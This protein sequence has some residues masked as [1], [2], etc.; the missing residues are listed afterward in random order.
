MIFLHF[1][2]FSKHFKS[3]YTLSF[4]LIVFVVLFYHSRDNP[5][6]FQV[7]WNSF[8]YTCS[9]TLCYADTIRINVFWCM[10]KGNPSDLQPIDLEIDRNFHRGVR[11]NRNPFVHPA[12]SVTFSYSF[13]SPYT[14][15]TPHFV[16]SLHSEHT[17]HSD[18]FDFHTNNMAQPPPHERTM[19]EL[20]APEFTYD[21]LCIQYHE[22]E[23]PYV[24]KNRL[25]HLLP[26]FH[27]LAGEEDPCKHLKQFH[28]VCST[29]TPTDVQEDHVY[30][31]A[32]PHSLEGNAKDWLYYL[33]PR[34]ITS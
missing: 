19:S 12:Y 6:N 22:E 7:I 15:K 8:D 31:K 2:H 14:P 26:K 11:H 9:F 4:E 5:T 21:S 18:R 3:T 16:H 27:G 25:I 34:S 23:V 28:V 10:T 29:M 1:F 24:L 30:L 33:A 17:V 20:T 32:F 13:D